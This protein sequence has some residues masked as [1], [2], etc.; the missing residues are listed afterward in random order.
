M[1]LGKKGEGGAIVLREILVPLLKGSRRIGIVS[2]LTYIGIS[3]LVGDGVIT[4]AISILSAE[5]GL[6]LLPSFKHTSQDTLIWIALAIA[7]ALFL[8]QRK[9]TE[10]IAG[11]LG[12]LMVIWF[13]SLTVS[14]L[15][16]ILRE[17]AV[18]K[19]LNAYYAVSFLMENG[20]S[21]FFVLSQVILCATGGEALYADMR[22][23]G[24]EPIL[25]ARGFVFVALLPNCLGRAPISP[26]TPM[27]KT[28]SS[29]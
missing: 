14:G 23:L 8:F 29:R 16:N 10:R 27:L 15:F 13:V 18:L 19:A 24:R 28:C 17:S 9:A 20:I 4:P 21:G 12:P 22:H 26:V 3:L 7:L 6:L 11:A 25:K 1:S 2:V 5:E